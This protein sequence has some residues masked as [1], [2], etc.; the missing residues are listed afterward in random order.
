MQEA[1]Q[2]VKVCYCCGQLRP[3]PNRSGLWEY[4]E[5][6]IFNPD[7]T[8]TTER[9]MEDIIS[10]EDGKPVVPPV[11]R[12]RTYPVD[13]V[14]QQVNIVDV[15]HLGLNGRLLLVDINKKR[16]S[17]WPDKAIWRKVGETSLISW[18]D[19]VY[20]GYRLGDCT[21]KPDG[22]IERW[23]KYLGKYDPEEDEDEG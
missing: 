13:Q 3:Y 7:G 8:L 19:V 5:D 20:D 12:K 10:F 9:V 21:F 16:S 14:W 2:E 17:W 23:G 15:S 4:L 22:T 11:V 1:I 18:E 6:P